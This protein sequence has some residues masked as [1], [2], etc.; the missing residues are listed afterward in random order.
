MIFSTHLGAGASG[1]VWLSNDR[2]YVIKLFLNRDV[3]EHEADIL[4]K[5]QDHLGLA[6][7]TFHGLYS[8]GWRFGVVTRFMGS[9]IGP[10][11]HAPLDQRYGFHVVAAHLIFARQQLLTALHKLH[12]CGIH[13]H[14]VRPANIMVDNSGA[15]TL[16]DFDRAEEV[17]GECK[18][19]S[20][21]EV[22]SSLETSI[23]KADPEPEIGSYL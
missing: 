19:C 9:A 10:L 8:D 5:C 12:S 17:Y 3:A 18:G 13:H 22:I 11:D 16:I 4:L 7:A 23:R 20:D 15:V 14:D 21:L 6:V 2:N 1:D